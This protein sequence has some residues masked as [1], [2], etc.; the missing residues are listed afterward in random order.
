MKYPFFAL[1][2]VLVGAGCATGIP[3]EPT[4]EQ[5]PVIT[6]VEEEQEEKIVA[7]PTVQ[8]P[9][10]D[11]VGR[12]YQKVFGEYIQDRFT[13]YHAGDDIEYSDVLSDV[14]VIA[15]AEGVVRS[16]SVVGGYG[17]LIT[18]EHDIDGKSITALYGHVDINE[19]T[20]L[21]GDN[22]AMGQQIAY[23]GEHLSPETDG[24]RKH[25]HFA[26]YEGTGSRINGYEAGS[27]GLRGWINPQIF[28]EQQGI[29]MTATRAFGD[30]QEAGGETFQLSFVVPEG[31]EVEY[32]PSIDS[33]NLFTVSGIGVARDRSQIFIRYFDAYDFLTLPTVTIHE[34]EDL[35]VGSQRN[36]ARRYDIEKKSDVT[37]FVD[38]P[39]W[40]NERHIVTDVRA[41]EGF[42]RYY[43]IAT[44]PELD[45]KI[46]EAFLENFTIK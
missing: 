27:S 24:E 29:D 42:T 3:T 32:V 43:V 23:L 45:T 15:I 1:S 7:A 16:A 38:Q 6:Q 41:E 28:F 39:T 36:T 11:Y 9:I 17:G 35:I 46:Y 40:R 44:N 31:M 14:P 18:I 26:L 37:N 12:R 22:V 30:V 25:L 20:V 4:N 21:V 34:T 19:A 10:E 5:P 8:L 2:I 13:G 33:L